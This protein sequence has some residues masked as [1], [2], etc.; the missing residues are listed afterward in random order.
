[1]KRKGFIL[2]WIGCFLF[3]CSVYP[4][5]LIMREKVIIYHVYK[6]YAI[7]QLINVHSRMDSTTVLNSPFMLTNNKIQ[8]IT[9]D[10]GIVAPKTINPKIKHIFKMKILINGEEKFPESEVT[11]TPEREEDSRFLSWLNVV[12]IREQ[13]SGIEKT[14]IIQRLSSDWIPGKKNPSHTESQ[15]WRII[16]F[17]GYNQMEEEVFGYPDRGKHPLGVRLIQESQMS[18]TLIGFKSDVLTYLPSYYYP[19]IYPQLT[20]WVGVVLLIW[21]TVRFAKG[22]R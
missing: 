18:S 3:F 9:E 11:L 6:N 13:D 17:T 12:R 21:G 10:T 16:Y 7:E 15:K 5:F 14:A 19:A 2:I 22:R 4:M 20:F 8:V 1:M